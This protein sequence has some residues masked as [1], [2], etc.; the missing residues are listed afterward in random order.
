VLHI[1]DDPVQQQAMRLRL[2]AMKEF[3]FRVTQAVS[4]SEAVEVFRRDRFDVVLLDYHLAQ[5]NGLGCLKQ[6]RALDPMV[7]VVVISGVAQPQLAAE[8]LDAG[9]DDFV[10]KE[11]VAGQ[12]LLRSLSAAVARAEAIRSRLEGKDHTPVDE[13]FDRVRRTVGVSDESEMLRSLHELQDSG[14]PRHFSAGQI[15]RL[16]D[17]VCG[18]LD[19]AAPDEQA[20]PR[21]AMLALFMRLFGGQA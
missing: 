10:S 17:L 14:W 3:S 8:L 20:A 1:E 19:Q 21:K 12:T 5:G 7:P 9:A 2:A 6:L 16:V 13:F 18:E 11:N 15:Q 4:E